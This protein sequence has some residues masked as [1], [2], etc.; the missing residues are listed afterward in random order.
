M[1]QKNLS[2]LRVS[3]IG[4][5]FCPITMRDTVRSVRNTRYQGIQ[6][7]DRTTDQTFQRLEM[8]IVNALMEEIRIFLEWEIDPQLSKYASS[9]LYG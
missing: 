7:N 1:E 4:H 9:V 5:I 8:R 6:G 3:Q 2:T